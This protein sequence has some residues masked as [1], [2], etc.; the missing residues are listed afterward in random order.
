MAS[1]RSVWRIGIGILL[2]VVVCAHVIF[3]SKVVLDWEAV[4]L[5]CVAV[6]LMFVPHLELFLPFVKSI[7]IGEAQIELRERAAKLA[8]AIEKLE[9][10]LPEATAN[11][12]DEG[13]IVGV[14]Q[15]KQLVDT[16]FE[17]HILDLAAKDKPAALMRLAVEIEKELLI[18]QGALGL[19]NESG[20]RGFREVVK[21]LSDRG[22]IGPD[23]RKGL[24]E[25]RSVRNK[26]A[27]SGIYDKA[28]VNSALDSGLR[29]LRLIKAI[30]RATYTVVDPHVD[31]F[32][33]PEGLNGITQY[34]G[35]MVEA[36]QPDGTKLRH[37]FPAGRQFVAG[38]RVG[39]DW[40]FTKKY[41]P[42]YYVVP[43]TGPT[44][45][46]GSSLGFVGKALPF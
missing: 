7:K 3:P 11:A 36:L 18:L 23:L 45:A 19:R 9:E 31:L 39:W 12:R 17:S 10:K 44:M 32:L 40:D 22:T 34:H 28:A 16:D 26:I 35:V 21:Q 15:L 4:S 5:L 29:L 25:F 46:F 38:E 42:A 13:P 6:I 14:E 1:K 43:G 27:H 33:D 8:G 24:L 2:L 41:G 30:P 37:V 20:A